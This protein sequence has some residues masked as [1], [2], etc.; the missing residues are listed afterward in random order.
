MS[1]EVRV[2][3][4]PPAWQLAHLSDPHLSVPG[5]LGVH[6]WLGKR[7][8]GYLSWR[9]RRR[10]EHR[11]E[12]LAAL[13]ADLARDPPE[14]ILVTGDLT[15]L[16]TPGEFI[17]GR[18]WLETL[19]P[20]QRV[21]LVPGNHDC[22]RSE[23]W[24]GTLAHW[25]PYLDGDG[26]RA[27][28]TFPSLRRRGGLALIGLSSAVPTPPLLA[29]GRVGET[30]LREL[31]SL[32]AAAGRQGLFRV[33]YLHHSPVPGQD[34][35]RKRLVDAPAVAGVIARA[36]AELVLHG[37]RHRIRAATLESQGRRIPVHGTASASALGRHGE[38]GGYS[39]YLV[40]P[41]E[42]EW[43]LELERRSYDGARFQSCAKLEIRIP[44][45]AQGSDSAAQPACTRR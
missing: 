7:A 30:Q 31:E 6:D 34:P 14:Q 8:L 22:T 15:Q 41:G 21:G 42:R 16:G 9:R 4:T 32:L 20:P 5:S 10:F 27:G 29:T 44:R 37:H 38:A 13:G 33:V 43:R 36:G 11:A 2:R 1:A 28:P 3:G 19:G 39:R 25:Q 45:P 24:A 18:R 17:Q 26:P 12:V 40:L 23:P 35:W